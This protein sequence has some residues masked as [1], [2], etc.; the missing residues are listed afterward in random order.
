MLSLVLAC[1]WL[2][3]HLND[4]PTAADGLLRPL[5]QPTVFAAKGIAA[6]RGGEQPD[7][8]NHVVVRFATDVK[9][10]RCKAQVLALCRPLCDESDAS[11][12]GNVG[13][14]CSSL[15]ARAYVPRRHA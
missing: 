5:Q 4:T 1:L 14:G 3:L 8:A 9:T 15:S 6:S 12:A 13:R 11:L 10:E 7:N 2:R